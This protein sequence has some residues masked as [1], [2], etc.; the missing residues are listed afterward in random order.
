MPDLSGAYR[1]L[2]AELDRMP[3]QQ[4]S[5][6]PQP[7][8]AHDWVAEA[9]RKAGNDNVPSSVLGRLPPVIA[10]TGPAGSGKSTS[11]AFLVENYGYTLVKFAAGLKAMM[12]TIGLNDRHIEGDLKEVPSKL[13]CGKTPRYAMQTIGTEWGR[14]LIGPDLWPN[15]WFDTACDVLDQGGRVVVD[16]CRFAN[17]A[18]R[19]RELHGVIYELRGRGGIAGDHVSESYRPEADVVLANTG[20]VQWLN[21]QIGNALEPRL[22]MKEAA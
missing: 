13:L 16:D 2:S 20:D 18:A 10:L 15:I 17:E 1:Y 22:T 11:A 12:R 8:P 5:R 21:M 7:M 14:D 4:D 19:V 9:R 3:T 6:T